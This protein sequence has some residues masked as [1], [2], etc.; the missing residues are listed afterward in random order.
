MPLLDPIPS[1]VLTRTLPPRMEP[2][3]ALVAV[4]RHRPVGASIRLAPFDGCGMDQ[5]AACAHSEVRQILAEQ[6]LFRSAG[7]SS[8]AVAAKRRLR[9]Q[10]SKQ[11][12]CRPWRGWQTMWPR[13]SRCCSRLRC[14]CWQVPGLSRC[15]RH[16]CRAFGHLQRRSSALFSRWIVADNASPELAHPSRAGAPAAAD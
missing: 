6:P 15:Q 1:P 4:S 16:W 14:G 5:A 2:L 12:S 9:A 13:G 8:H 3:L 11:P 10:H 7:C